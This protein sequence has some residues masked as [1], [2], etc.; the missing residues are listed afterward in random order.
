M[1]HVS[2]YKIHLLDSPENTVTKTMMFSRDEANEENASMMIYPDDSIEIVKLKISKAITGSDVVNYSISPESMYLFGRQFIP[3]SE[4]TI[5]KMYQ[6]ITRHDTR[7]LTIPRVQAYL[8]NY[9]ISMVM[10]ASK[11]SINEFLEKVQEHIQSSKLGGAL[12]YTPLGF[13]YNVRGQTE[14]DTTFPVNP[15]RCTSEILHEFQEGGVATTSI[16]LPYDH[17]LLLKYLPLFQNEIYVCFFKNILPE[18]SKY[19]FPKNLGTESHTMKLLKNHE[20]KDPTVDFF[21][22]IAQNP[23]TIPRLEKYIKSFTI[24]LLNRIRIPLDIIFKNVSANESIPLI[25][26]NPGKNKENILRLFSL[27][28]SNSGRRIPVLS[29]RQITDFTKFSKRQ[30][31]TFLLPKREGRSAEASS[32]TMDEKDKDQILAADYELYVKLNSSGEL[33]IHCE[34]R[35][36]SVDDLNRILR[37]KLNP[38]LLYLNAFLEKSGYSIQLFDEIG[39]MNVGIKHFHEQWVVSGVPK[40]VQSFSILKEIPCIR[41]IFDVYDDV[42]GL[43]GNMEGGENDDDDSNEIVLRYKRMYNDT[44]GQGQLIKE[45]KHMKKSNKLI[46]EALII[47]Y[48]MSFQQANARLEKYTNEEEERIWAKSPNKEYFFPIQFHFDNQ[49]M[50]IDI[51]KYCRDCGGSSLDIHGVNVHGIEEY[52]V[53]PKMRIHKRRQ[54]STPTTN[55]IVDIPRFAHIELLKMYVQ[56]ILQIVL[57]LNK[58]SVPVFCEKMTFEPESTMEEPEKQEVPEPTFT[59]EYVEEEEED[60]DEEEEEEEDEEEEE[61]E[62]DDDE[63][64]FLF[65]GVKKKKY[66]TK[67][68]RLKDADSKLFFTSTKGTNEESYGRICQK[69]HQPIVLN[70]EEYDANL[71]TNPDLKAVHYATTP[72]KKL[73]YMCP[74]YWCSITNQILTEEEYNQGV[75][76]DH[77]EISKYNNPSFEDSTKHPHPEGHCLPC[78]FKGDVTTKALHKDR[79]LKCQQG[80]QEASESLLNPVDATNRIFKEDRNILKYSSNPPLTQGRWGILPKSVQ[81]FLNIDYSKMVVNTA[82]STKIIQN[83][84]CFLLYGIEHPKRQSFLGLFAEI[85][86]YKNKLKSTISTQELR[87]LLVSKVTLDRFLHCQNGSFPSVFGVNSRS[88]NAPPLKTYSNTQFYKTID[89]HN[90]IQLAFLEKVVSSFENFVAFLTDTQTTIDHMYLWEL[91]AGDFPELIPGG[92]NLVILELSQEDGMIDYLCPPSEISV[93]DSRK[94]TFFVLKR[95]QYYEPIYQ[96]LDYNGKHIVVT[97]G[98]FLEKTVPYSS[99]RRILELM[100]SSMHKYCLPIHDYQ[101]YPNVLEVS[102]T[103]PMDKYNLSA[104]QIQIILHKFNYTIH[105]QVWNTQGKIVGFYISRNNNEKLGI[106]IPCFPSGILVDSPYPIIYIHPDGSTITKKPSVTNISLWKSYKITLVRLNSV[107][108]DTNREILCDPVHKIIDT[109]SGNITGIMTETNQFVPIFPHET[110]VEDE[111]KPLT[112][113][114]DIE[115]DQTLTLHQQG[116]TERKNTIQKISLESQFYQVFR[117]TLRQLLNQY[118]SRLEKKTILENIQRYNEGKRLGNSDYTQYLKEI[119]I[120]LR[121]ISKNHVDFVEYSLEDLNMFMT[122]NIAIHECSQNRPDTDITACKNGKIVIPKY[123]LM[124]DTTSKNTGKDHSNKNIYYLR[125]ADEL[126]RYQR[127]QLFMFQTQT[128]L[129]IS[130]GMTDYRLLPTE[131]LLLESFLTEDYFRDMIPFNTSEYIHQTNYDTAEPA[132]MTNRTVHPILTLEDQSQM[133]RQIPEQIQRDFVESSCILKKGTKENFVEGNDRSIWKQAFPKNTREVFFQGSPSS[134]TFAVVMN[135]IKMSGMESKTLP[136]I[137]KMLWEAYQPYLKDTLLTNKVLYTLKEQFKK[138]LLEST[139]LETA[140]M[141]ED[142]FIT[143][144]DLWVLA[145]YLDIPVILFSI[146][147]I[148]MAS[149]DHWLYLNTRSMKSIGNDQEI[150][151]DVSSIYRPILFIRSPLSVSEVG[152]GPSYSLIERSFTYDQLGAMADKIEE[153]IRNRTNQVI[154]LERFLLEK[155]VVVTKRNS[156]S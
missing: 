91:L 69:D 52:T 117:S 123:N 125:L 88:S 6:E 3:A 25:M 156:R 149:V 7:E 39:S 128:F 44:E 37:S 124:Y 32:S 71:E 21:Y 105:Y 153:G 33:Q 80:D 61:E 143:D 30:T 114:N 107:I 152:A 13:Q 78:C 106:F 130:A 129:N 4:F 48:R 76:K 132:F 115:S 139:D 14:R 64:V 67:L 15:Y 118:N 133:I 73:W 127:I 134:C 82:N 70:Q 141:T 110:P 96:Y 112:R 101:E 51:Y 136:E 74:K 60:V 102:E 92:C 98:F 147:Q 9:S 84:P 75:C 29:K 49:Q 56:S 34:N 151:E 58:I 144:L 59:D 46:I 108:E 154:S 122:S 43:G 5:E 83:Q 137:K 146:K 23:V 16:L 109:K 41:N 81:Y 24:V 145:T 138:K 45:F 27:R 90:P 89:L 142:Y 103:K 1:E 85:Y 72:N 42:G 97:K 131:I 113:S 95:D 22:K 116:D 19:Y 57:R 62:E 12:R 66:K 155:I 18:H 148:K 135:M 2:S 28:T 31:V 11:A 111:L 8:D 93:F 77:V 47:N 38:L 150:V 120:L 100:D 126:L 86:S 35:I 99:M 104:S 10:P 54:S 87:K 79:I 121:T 119:T 63:E 68:D 17:H 94:E 40:S 50:I 140:I 20:T 65:G 53:G 36:G 26:Y 55:H